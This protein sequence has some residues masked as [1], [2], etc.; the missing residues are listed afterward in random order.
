M[1]DK[2]PAG[3]GLVTHASGNGDNWYQIYSRPHFLSILD[4][5]GDGRNSNT[6][7]RR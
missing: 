1:G 7:I 6:K 3:T 2:V 4:S 5:A